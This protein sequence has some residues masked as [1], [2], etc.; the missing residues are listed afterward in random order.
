MKM[1][2]VTSLLRQEKTAL[3]SKGGFFLLAHHRTLVLPIALASRFLSVSSL[4]A[5]N[6]SFSDCDCPFCLLFDSLFD[7]FYLISVL[8]NC[9]ARAV[10]IAA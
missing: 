1:R 4:Q 3:R 5:C 7:V 10:R 6:N 9:H 2:I 8:V